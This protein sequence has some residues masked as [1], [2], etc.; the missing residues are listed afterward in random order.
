M[1][2]SRKALPALPLGAA[3]VAFARAGAAPAYRPY[4]NL[5]PGRPRPRWASLPNANRNPENNAPNAN[6]REKYAGAP[7]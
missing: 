6:R 1:V 4:L 5:V 2:R 3:T 7:K